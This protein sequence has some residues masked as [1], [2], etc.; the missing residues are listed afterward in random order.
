MRPLEG[1][2]STRCTV[3]LRVHQRYLHS[4]EKIDI[5]NNHPD[6]LNVIV[7]RLDLKIT[8]TFSQEAQLHH[9]IVGFQDG[10]FWLQHGA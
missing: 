7:L 8:G 6:N 5:L 10:G 9:N 1:D 4:R 3:V 2:K